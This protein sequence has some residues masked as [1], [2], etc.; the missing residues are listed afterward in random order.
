MHS[1]N[2]FRYVIQL[3]KRQQTKFLSSTFFLKLKRLEIKEKLIPQ[4][5]DLGRKLA[6][7]DGNDDSRNWSGEYG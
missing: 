4:P 3:D 2:L 7:K 6:G 5:F 1:S